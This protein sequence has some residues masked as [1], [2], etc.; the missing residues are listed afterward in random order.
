MSQKT[1]TAQKGFHSPAESP[2]HDFHA[3]AAVNMQAI[4]ESSI[5]V[6]AEIPSHNDAP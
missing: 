2:S 6:C 1:E 3:I 4:G 5:V